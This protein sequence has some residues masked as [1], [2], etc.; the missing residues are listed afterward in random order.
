MD[1]T[2]DKY[3]PD[4]NRLNPLLTIVQTVKGITN[5]LIG[6]FNL[7]KTDRMKAGIQIRSEEQDE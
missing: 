3:E 5:R 6:F 7:T 1:S 2:A 4:M